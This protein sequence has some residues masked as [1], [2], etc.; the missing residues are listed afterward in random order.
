MFKR[1][2]FEVAKG[3]EERGINLPI[4]STTRS[5]GFDFEAAEDVIIPALWKQLFQVRK[6]F[7]FRTAKEDIIGA[8]RPVK[9]PTG[10]KSYMENDEVLYLYSRSSNSGKKLLMMADGVGVVDGDYYGNIKNDGH[11]FFQLINFGFLDMTIKKGE[12]IGQGVFAKFL[13]ADDDAS[14]KMNQTRVGG[15]GTT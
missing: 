5:A 8:L 1:R 2:G 15:S 11:I 6:N 12:R 10:I 4:R 3:F 13:D 7:T 14:R 9:V